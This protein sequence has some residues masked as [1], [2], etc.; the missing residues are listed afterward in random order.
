MME[1]EKSRNEVGR[2]MMVE[3]VGHKREG[4]IAKQFKL[5]AEE[6]AILQS[7]VKKLHESLALVLREPSPSEA[8]EEMARCSK[9]APLVRAIEE[10]QIQVLASRKELQDILDRLEL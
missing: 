4:M 9:P 3:D 8:G 6:I 1:S 7:T 2:N 10:L 5:L